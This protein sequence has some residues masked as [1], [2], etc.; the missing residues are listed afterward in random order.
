MLYI[1]KADSEVIH[2]N[3][4]GSYETQIKYVLALMQDSERDPFWTTSWAMFGW[5][6]Y[7]HSETSLYQFRSLN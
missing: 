7:W 4:P 6:L 5:D 1:Q 2:M 3:Q